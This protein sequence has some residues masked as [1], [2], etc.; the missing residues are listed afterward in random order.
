MAE[1]TTGLRSA[2]TADGIEIL[3]FNIGESIYGIEIKYVNEIINIEQITV[4][5]KLPDYIKGVINIR[6]KVVPIISVRNRFGIEEIPYDD[7]TCIIVLEF[8]NGDQVGI[9]VD[10]VQEVLVAKPGDISKAPDSKNVNANR[11]IKS[12]IEIEGDIKLLLDCDKL[13]AD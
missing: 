4:V 12:I 8:E 1:N 10:R 2:Y 11:Y 6:G 7:R 5:P 9:I 3:F 13:I